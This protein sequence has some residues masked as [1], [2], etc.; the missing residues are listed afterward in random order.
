MKSTHVV[1]CFNYMPI[2]YLSLNPFQNPTNL[3]EV[4]LSLHKLLNM[5]K[6]RRKKE[7]KK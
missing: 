2:A 5:Q 6:L 3:Y 4:M 1:Q 7:S